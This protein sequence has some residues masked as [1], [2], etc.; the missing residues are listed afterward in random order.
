M[1]FQNT[2]PLEI[3]TPLIS[4]DLPEEIIMENIWDFSDN[5]DWVSVYTGHSTG[6][7]KIITN[8]LLK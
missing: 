2:M 6:K 1:S 5:I 4:T 3:G 7:F 8:A